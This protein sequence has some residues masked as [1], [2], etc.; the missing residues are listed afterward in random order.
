MSRLTHALVASALILSAGAASAQ[1][2]TIASGHRTETATVQAIEMV[3]RTVV[4]RLENGELR[5]VRAPSSA[6]RLSQVK[7]GD[8]V[9]A[10]YYENIVLRM[11]GEDESAVDTLEATA[12]GTSGTQPGGTMATQMTITATITAIDPEAPSITFS[13]PRG[14]MYTTSVRDKSAL[15]AVTVGQRVDITWTDATLVSVSPQAK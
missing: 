3:S 2:K 7:V 1:I 13:G 15:K 10:T 8:T 6:A 11:K 12:V 9:K 14:W 4:L 5:T